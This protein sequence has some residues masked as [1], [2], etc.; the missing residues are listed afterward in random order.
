MTTHDYYY[1]IVAE[2]VADNLVIRL[3]GDFDPVSA[4]ALRRCIR[5]QFDDATRNIVLDCSAA[6]YVDSS[7]LRVLLEARDHAHAHGGVATV[8]RPSA[9]V[10][11]VIE[12]SGLDAVLIVTDPP[13]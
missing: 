13:D 9:T 1:D 2:Q 7:G 5:D 11:R 3:H 12:A 10:R 8:H 6:T 4:E